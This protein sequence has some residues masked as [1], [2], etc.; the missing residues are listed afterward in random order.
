MDS[1]CVS[2]I[3][4]VWTCNGQEGRPWT[5]SRRFRRFFGARP[6]LVRCLTRSTWSKEGVWYY[7]RQK[8]ENREDFV[9]LGGKAGGSAE[10]PADRRKGRRI[11]GKAGGS[12][13][14]PADRRKG[15][16]I[17]GKAGGSA[18]RPA[19]KAAREASSGRCQ[20]PFFAV[21]GRWRGRSQD[22]GEGGTAALRLS[23]FPRGGIGP[24]P[25]IAGEARLLAV[26][27][28]DGR[29]SSRWS[30]SGTSHGS[31]ASRARRASEGTKRPRPRAGRLPSK[32]T[33]ALGE[34]GA[35]SACGE[36]VVCRPAAKTW[37]VGLRA[38]AKPTCGGN[39]WPSAGL[40]PSEQVDRLRTAM[41]PFRQS[42]GRDTEKGAGWHGSHM[43]ARRPR[44]RL[45]LSS[46][47]S[48]PSASS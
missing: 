11:G 15:Q 30:A 47:P 29:P 26:G 25:L 4:P 17:G 45:P 28:D 6:F 8:I 7:F 19:D 39:R 9:Q 23:C 38:I 42:A 14:R 43:A 21:E 33:S 41:V 16:R 27:I 12:A 18:E 35:S 5:K 34:G 37:S 32:G 3:V 2:P 36:N 24:R 1:L 48:G 44:L 10:R 31:Q 20:N 46:R 13:E 22:A 40:R